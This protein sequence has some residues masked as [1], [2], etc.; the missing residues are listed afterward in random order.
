MVKKGGIVMAILL[1]VD[2]QREF[3]T[4]EK[5][6]EVYKRCVEYINTCR[7]LYTH[8]VWAAVYQNGESRNMHLLTRWSDMQ[9]IRKMDFKPDKMFLHSGYSAVDKMTFPDHVPIDVIGLDTDACVLAHCF[10]MFDRDIRFRVIVDG[11]YS[12]GGKDM[13]EAGLACMKRQFNKAVDEV[14]R[15]DEIIK[16]QRTVNDGTDIYTTKH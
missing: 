12:S 4:D 15:L 5:G 8:G 7:H 2:L 6:I 16:A 11:V 9:K 3:A 10:A 13:H 14:T 1:A